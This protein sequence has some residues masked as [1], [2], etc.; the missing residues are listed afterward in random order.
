MPIRSPGIIAFQPLQVEDATSESHYLG[1]HPAWKR[2]DCLQLFHLSHSKPASPWCMLPWR[3]MLDSKVW[4]VST[5]MGRAVFIIYHCILWPPTCGYTG[6]PGSDKNWKLDLLRDYVTA[7]AD[8]WLVTYIPDR[9]LSGPRWAPL[10][11]RKKVK[12]LSTWSS[13]AAWNPVLTPFAKL[14]IL[15]LEGSKAIGWLQDPEY[16]DAS[17]PKISSIFILL[18][19]R[20]K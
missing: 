8:L 14:Y 15:Q 3:V 19:F 1:S 18:I 7:I 16:G 11:N 12:I 10:K 4:G 6:L 13:S 9:S 20:S 2:P 5:S 17:Y